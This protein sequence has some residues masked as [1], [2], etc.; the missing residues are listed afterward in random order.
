MWK[1]MNDMC[2]VMDKPKEIKLYKKLEKCEFHQTKLE[3]FR[4]MIS[5]NDICMDPCKVQ[6][7]MD[8][9][10]PTYVQD[11]QCFLGFTKF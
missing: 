4:H 10:T 6:T 5:K 7:I 11:V 8:L 9:V 1:N 2:D 3:F